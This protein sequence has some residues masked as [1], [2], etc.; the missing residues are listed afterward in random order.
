MFKTICVGHV[1]ADAVTKSENG[2]TF[3]TFRVAHSERWTDANGQQRETTQWIDCI[4]NDRPK[5]CDYLVKGALV[6]VSG[7]ARLRCYSS[8][9]ARGFVAGITIN[10]PSVELLGGKADLVPSK[11]YDSAGIMHDV[12][13]FYHVDNANLQDPIL[14]NAQG[15]AFAVDDNGWVLPLDMVQNASSTEQTTAQASQN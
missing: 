1:G 2:R 5:V 13:K 10:N 9:K 8:E 15:R 12:N 7:N 6:Y 11:L 14:R 3:T 4:M